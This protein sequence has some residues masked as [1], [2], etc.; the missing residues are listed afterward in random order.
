M[1][2]HP[3]PRIRTDYP[4]RP[5]IDQRSWASPKPSISVQV[6]HHEQSDHRQSVGHSRRFDVRI[7]QSQYK[8]SVLYLFHTQA[9]LQ[10][11][12]LVCSYNQ[13]LPR[14]TVHPPRNLHHR[15]YFFP[16]ISNLYYNVSVYQICPQG[17]TQFYVV[18]LY[19]NQERRDGY[20]RKSAAVLGY[21]RSGAWSGLGADPAGCGA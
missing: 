20:E 12:V 18:T 8:F 14:N 5:V 9:S 19:F 13:S 16:S 10:F 6:T 17:M 4:F 1:Y 2:F 15:L 3:V 11:R 21:H 7:R